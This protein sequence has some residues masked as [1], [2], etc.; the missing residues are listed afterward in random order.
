MTC[1]SKQIYNAI[2]AFLLTYVQHSVKMS[3]QKH[4]LYVLLVTVPVVSKRCSDSDH[5]WLL[6]LPMMSTL[7]LALTQASGWKIIH[8]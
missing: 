6:Q 7:M 8:R 2:S 4:K 1:I 5:T 3:R